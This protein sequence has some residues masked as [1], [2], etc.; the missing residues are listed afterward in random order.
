MCQGDC[1]WLAWPSGIYRPIRRMAVP[2][3]GTLL[4]KWEGGALLVG[5]GEGGLAD[6]PLLGGAFFGGDIACGVLF[7]G[8][9]FTEAFFD[10]S[11]S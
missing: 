5:G 9:L 3:G 2:A 4:G 6:G 10:D 7:E 8:T 1:Q 11:L